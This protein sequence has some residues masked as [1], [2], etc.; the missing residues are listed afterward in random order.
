MKKIMSVDFR[1]CLMEIKTANAHSSH[2]DVGFLSFLLDPMWATN[3]AVNFFNVCVG[4]LLI[5]PFVSN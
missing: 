5:L 3:A 2:K 1:N 4:Y